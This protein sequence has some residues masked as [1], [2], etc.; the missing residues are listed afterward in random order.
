[1]RNPVF[2]VTPAAYVDLIVTE[3]GA[4]PPSLAYVILK[5]Y[6]GWSI[7]EFHKEFR[8]NGRESES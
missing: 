2:D 1:V 6:L 8:M 7:E 3:E 5:E 4:I